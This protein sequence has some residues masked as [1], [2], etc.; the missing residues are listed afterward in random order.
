MKDRIAPDRP[1]AA[2]L[3]K[4]RDQGPSPA[5]EPEPMVCDGCGLPILGEP[6]GRGMLIWTRG[7]Q[8][9]VEQ[10]PLC[11]ACARAATVAGMGM[12]DDGGGGEEG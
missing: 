3:I 9:R 6:A 4:S 10:P 2:A 5:P 8:V 1:D 11:E 7:E 12:W